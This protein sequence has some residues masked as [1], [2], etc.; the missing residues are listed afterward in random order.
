MGLNI[1]NEQAHRLATEVAE[2]AGE[3][4]TDA[5]TNALRERLQRLESQNAMRKVQRAQ[6]IMEAARKFREQLAEPLPGHG[7]FLYDERGLPK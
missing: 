7:E 3:T 4:L 1:K 6:T 5:V 2:L